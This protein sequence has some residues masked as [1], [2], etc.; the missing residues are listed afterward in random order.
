MIWSR[1]IQPSQSKKTRTGV[2]SK[3]KEKKP[4][5]ELQ[6]MK[7]IAAVNH[8]EDTD[9]L[10]KE[11]FVDGTQPVSAENR[12]LYNEGPISILDPTKTEEQVWNIYLSS[13]GTSFEKNQQEI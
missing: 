3:K 12:I 5:R 10:R 1:P 13:F 8:A 4:E 11:K 2:H 9:F 6:R 7:R